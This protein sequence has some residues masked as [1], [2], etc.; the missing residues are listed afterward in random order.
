MN[1]LFPPHF[2]LDDLEFSFRRQYSKAGHRQSVIGL[3]IGLVLALVAITLSFVIPG[4]SEHP[5]SELFLLLIRSLIALVLAIGLIGLPRREKAEPNDYFRWVVMPAAFAIV[6]LV[7]NYWMAALYG[8]DPPPA[9]R[10]FLV[11]SLALW[12]FCAFARPSS[13]L[14]TVVACISSGGAATAGYISEGIGMIDTAPYLLIANFSAVSVTI[15]SEKRARAL[16]QRT[17]ELE[18][19]Q[20]ELS[21]K[22]DRAVRS[23]DFKSRV[24]TTIS[25][26][27]RQPLLGAD[28][29]LSAQLT[30]EDG[31]D[32]S[33]LHRVADA[34]RQIQAGLEE[35]LRAAALDEVD[36]EK[37]SE[38][39]DLPELIAQAIT[40]IEPLAR[41]LG[42]DIYWRNHL[43]TDTTVLSSPPA[44][45]AALLNLLGNALKFQ[46]ETANPWVLIRC[47]VSASSPKLVH[48]EIIDNGPGI[49]P[50]F[51]SKVFTTG[52]RLP[53]DNRVPGFGIGL[54][55]VAEQMR[56]LPHHE[57]ILMARCR[58]GAR[59][60]LTFPLASPGSRAN[61]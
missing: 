59:F 56:E 54:A 5:A 55:S 30:R 37:T 16:Y 7:L 4:G 1:N 33:S 31:P 14:A 28:L 8:N 26:D 17:L 27:L 48:V 29:L 43:P 3:T 9:A 47:F 22:S 23:R 42:I 34:L 57:V 58:R 52:Y 40:E 45:R 13:R 6:A 61:M 32:P 11:S 46:R 60:R 15:Q 18:E 10:I 25:H 39:I 41:P 19:S 24:L 50:E 53:R 44:V 21:A 49:D 36:F 51:A 38:P 12:L 2:P 20:R 35:I